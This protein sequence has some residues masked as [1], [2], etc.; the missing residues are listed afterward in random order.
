MENETAETF[1]LLA[2]L[3]QVILLPVAA[4]V[5]K[6]VMKGWKADTEKIVDRRIE[7]A[8]RAVTDKIEEHAASDERAFERFD[9]KLDRFDEK[10]D[11]IILGRR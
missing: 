8:N 11:R 7:T 10:L 2:T 5:A 9:G 6:Q 1:H 4:F 3:A